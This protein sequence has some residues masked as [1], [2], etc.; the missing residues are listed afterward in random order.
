[1]NIRIVLLTFL[2]VS[3]TLFSQTIKSPEAFLGYPIGTQF[4]RHHKVVEYFKY[5]ST[6]LPN[7]QLEKYGV[8]N[9]GRPLYVSYISSKKNME[10]LENI[11]LSHLTQ[12][13]IKNT[14]H[15]ENNIA[16]VWLSY[17]VHGNE[18][19]STEAAMQTLYELLTQKQAYLENTLV[20]IDPCMNPDGRD[21]YVN[22]FRQVKSTP[23]NSAQDAKEHHEPWPGGR[24]NHYLFDLN[25]DWV[26]ATQVESVQRLRIYNKWM[27]HIHVDFHEQYINNP[28]YFAPAA[29]PFHEIISDWQRDFQTQIGKNHAAYFDKNGWLY[30]TKESFDLLYPSYGDTYPTFMGAIGM[31]YE[32]AGH[33]MA[34]LGVDTDHGYELTLTDRVLHHKTTGLSTI[35]M[36][37]KNATKLNTEFKKFFDNKILI[38][39]SYVLKNE[40]QD[41]INRLKKLLDIHEIRYEF[42][43]KGQV[44]GYHYS[45]GKES[46]MPV[47]ERDMVI[48]TDQPKG[49]M[50]KVLFEPATKLS[51][52]LTYDNTAWSIPYAHGF[53]AVA[54]KTKVVSGK[55]EAPR[56]SDNLV[57]T[58]AYAYLAKWNSL[59]D[60]TFLAA[61]LNADIRVRYAEKAFSLE[62][63]FYGEG[64]LIMLRNDHKNNPDFDRQLV[65]I[66][67]RLERK[68]IPVQTGFVSKGADFGS[69]SVKPINKQ[70]VA[71][72]SGKGVSSLNFGELWHFFETQLKYPLTILDTDYFNGVNLTDYD[73]LIIPEGHYKNILDKRGLEK[74]KLF[75][76]S[77]GTVIVIGN[78]I[79]NFADKNMFAIK[80]EK[81]KEDKKKKTEANLTPYD[82]LKR[83]STE[84]FIT[85]AIFRSKVDATHPLA[86]GYDGSYFSL[87]LGN[88]SYEYLKNGGNVAYFTKDAKHIS[89]YAGKKALE[90]I[91][92]SLLIGEEKAG[93]G[94]IIYMVDNPL[95]RSF[96]ENGKLFFV[97]AVFF[98]NSAII[99]R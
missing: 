17:N 54:S 5:V 24:V 97:N 18:A 2:L 62:E 10:N 47:T 92:E 77:G 99:K 94:S 87:K 25:R 51:D 70:K 61:M 4:T 53:K 96:W 45:T 16:I 38:Y 82:S 58:S 12:T 88:R 3:N 55:K 30:F 86:F 21:R 37:S 78:A 59:E 56:F 71:I 22:W 33:G 28:Y 83:K 68:I 63:N 13:G 93:S 6:T 34:G 95:F 20:M 75:S 7:V 64:T 27:P 1:M 46:K 29:E 73:V 76:Q 35:E 80:T 14:A 52:S 11:R 50:V 81:A 40:N 72:L 69:Y 32:Q 8:S 90:N 89:G 66:A 31:T 15:K 84:N 60:A 26:W 44:K 23:Y 48:H 67:N 9:E 43:K 91:P 65:N 42:A 79:R 85:G 49:K 57:N 98:R 74:V 36:A 39:K 41:K 19:S